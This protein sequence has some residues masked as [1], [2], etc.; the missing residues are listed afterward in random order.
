MH[1]RTKERG[2]GGEPCSCSLWSPDYSV[3]S[4]LPV[5]AQQTVGLGGELGD[6]VQCGDNTHV[7]RSRSKEAPEQNLPKMSSRA[8]GSRGCRVGGD[9]EPIFYILKDSE[10]PANI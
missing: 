4:A 6:A 8:L 3:K 2:G 7:A 10:C 1:A 5:H 9:V